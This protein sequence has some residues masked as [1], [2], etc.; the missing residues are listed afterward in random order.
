[1]GTLQPGRSKPCLDRRRAATIGRDGRRRLAGCE[2]VVGP[3]AGFRG[4]RRLVPVTVR[5]P[6]RS[7]LSGHGHR[8]RRSSPSAAA[9][10]SGAAVHPRVLGRVHRRRRLR[11]HRAHPGGEIPA[12]PAHRRRGGARVWGV[13]APVCAPPGRDMGLPRGPPAPLASPTRPGRR[14]SPGDGVRRGVDSVH[15]PGARSHPDAGGEP[16]RAR[17]DR[18]VAP[19][20]LAGPGRT[21]PPGGAGPATAPGHV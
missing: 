9:A 12:R 16:A 11:C 2:P 4:G 20:L 5:P 3:R 18:P 14:L 21:V 7:R 1:M 15:R 19:F 13:H 8:R 17:Q 10:A 6:A